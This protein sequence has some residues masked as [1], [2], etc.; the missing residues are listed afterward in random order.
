MTEMIKKHLLAAQQ[1]IFRM[2]GETRKI[3]P[4]CV[5][6]GNRNKKKDIFRAI[7]KS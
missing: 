6:Q 4:S 7:L 2:G 1:E 3:F 5:K